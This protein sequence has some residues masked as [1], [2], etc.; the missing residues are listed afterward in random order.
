MIAPSGSDS[1]RFVDPSAL[2]TGTQNDIDNFC[3]KY[4]SRA[5]VRRTVEG[6]LTG[7]SSPGK[8]PILSVAYD[9]RGSTV[10]AVKPIESSPTKI[11]DQTAT[12]LYLL[13]TADS[14][15][16]LPFC[17][18]YLFC[19]LFGA[20]AVASAS[21]R[22]ALNVFTFPAMALLEHSSKLENSSP[23]PSL[24]IRILNNEK[25][26]NGL[27]SY[28]YIQYQKGTFDYLFKKITGKLPSKEIYRELSFVPNWFSYI[29]TAAFVDDVYE[30]AK[31]NPQ[32]VYPNTAIYANGLDRISLKDL[33]FNHI[34]FPNPG[35]LNT[36][37]SNRRVLADPTSKTWMYSAQKQF[38]KLDSLFEKG[39]AYEVATTGGDF[40]FDID[41]CASAAESMFLPFDSKLT[42]SVTADEFLTD[43]L[44]SSTQRQLSAMMIT[45]LSRTAASSVAFSADN[46]GLSLRIDFFK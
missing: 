44:K 14:S 35:V 4:F 43:I 37:F 41:A 1:Q 26:V 10:A 17:D 16:V 8:R 38:S 23:L 32:R 12:M 39:T 40:V 9:K 11:I 29:L 46:T 5:V 6:L 33:Y 25:D 22:D 36:R 27:T 31:S 19:G 30:T 2:G 3:T 28:G 20:Y 42:A 15:R 21:S 34:W 24:K 13:K 18:N 45:R 7:L